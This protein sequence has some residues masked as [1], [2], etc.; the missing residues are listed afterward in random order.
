MLRQL[1]RP[2]VYAP[3]A[4]AAAL[5]AGLWIYPLVALT[6]ERARIQ[7][8]QMGLAYDADD[9]VARAKEGDLPAGRLFLRAGMAVDAPD[10]D[11]DTASGWAAAQGHREVLE[12][13]LE[14]GADPSR[15]LVWAA[16][17]GKAEILALL[18]QRQPGK[19]AVSEAMH[20]AAGTRYT[21]I[22]KTLLDAGA[23]VD[24]PWGRDGSTALIEA[25]RVANLATVQLL[26]GHGADVNAQN[27]YGATALMAVVN[28]GSSSAD[29]QEMARR[30]EIARVLLDKGADPDVR[31]RSMQTWQP[32]ALL[33][34]IDSGRAPMALLLI[35]RGAD[36]NAGTAYQGGDMRQL[37][38]LMRAARAGQAEV[39][40]ALLAKG[41]E[42]HARN[43]N[44][45]DALMESALADAPS[46]AV[47]KALLDGG[48][49]AHAVNV[50]QR[51][52]LMFIAR[53]RAMVDLEFVRL[54]LEH[55][56]QIE[57][58]DK[59]G[60]TP[61]MFAAAE[62]QTEVARELLRR[63]ARAGATDHAGL[64]ALS[65]AREAD[66]KEMLQLLTGAAARPAASR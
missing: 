5:L 23:V 20:N 30:L 64:S 3:L 45:N 62:G 22:V 8:V 15:P 6:P 34:A 32:T 28:S 47:A 48:A 56:A 17:H 31:M 42:V 27:T 66:H 53:Q 44:G 25:A 9:F 12:L 43:E 37:S 50:N 18:L 1:Q 24:T 60:R 65:L 61:L 19:S 52:A 36:V 33:V 2:V 55:G 16:G 11:G 21:G 13:L 54:L 57:A 51:T 10:R 26:L 41:A 35:E 46:A 29:A 49:D 4:A 59:E 7:I 58:I 38:A 14:H 63:G 40:A 39:V